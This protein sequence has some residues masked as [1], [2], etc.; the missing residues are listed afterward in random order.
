MVFGL[1]KCSLTHIQESREREDSGTQ[2]KNFGKSSDGSN[3]L[4]NRAV[5]NTSHITSLHS[6]HTQHPASVLPHLSSSG[7]RP[8]FMPVDKLR[9]PMAT[10]PSSCGVRKSL[11][12]L[13][14]YS[15][16]L[17]SFFPPILA[18][19]QISSSSAPSSHDHQKPIFM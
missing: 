19:S 2:F 3:P 16:S 6:L 14:D 18:P 8:L 7:A 17:A 11:V 5:A 13:E 10:K 1:Q 15:N 12:Y 4:G 9:V